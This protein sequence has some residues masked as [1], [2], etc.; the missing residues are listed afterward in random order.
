MCFSSRIRHTRW[1]R[2]WSSDV[3]SS[4]LIGID[5]VAMCVNDLVVSG[6][7]PLFFLDYY[8]TGRLDVDVAARVITGIGQGCEQAGC[9]LVGGETAEMPGMYQG[10]DYDLAGF[11]VEI[12]RAHV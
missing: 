9:A 5:L 2:D 11:C 12:G 8:A 10:S 3:C 7:E 1:P 6:A 4:D